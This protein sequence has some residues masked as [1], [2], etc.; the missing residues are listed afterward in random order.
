MRDQSS[1][2]TA[3]YSTLYIFSVKYNSKVAKS[4]TYRIDL[5]GGWFYV[6]S[7]RDLAKR[8]REHRRSLT[9]DT[10]FNQILQRAFDKH[11]GSFEFTVLGLHP[12][13]ELLER[14][15]TLLDAHR[16][17][18]KC[19]NIAVVAGSGMA[20]RTHSGESR[21]RMR[22]SHKGMTGRQHTPE[23]REKMSASQAGRK[24]GPPTAEARAN[25]SAAGKA[26]T[27]SAEHRA[28]LSAANK[29]RKASPAARAK[30][31]AAKKGKKLP[32]RSPE[33]C[34]A[35]SASHIGRPPHSDATRAKLSAANTG[36]KLSAE[37]RA[38]LSAALIGK[39]KTPD[40]CAAISAGKKGRTRSDASP[41]S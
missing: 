19:A 35:L 41:A 11:S 12:E 37:H 40:H 8:E 15:Q 26:K 29:G 22:D 20:G 30:M 5:G 27:F 18:P 9:T 24:A 38:K 33:W 32:P 4:G 25:M 39:K 34:A 10:H 14:E 7:S 23:T 36:R 21:T 13:D 31:S 17:D 3:S 1:L 2:S 28:A 16:D 6:G